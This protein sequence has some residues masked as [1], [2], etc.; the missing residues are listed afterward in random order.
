MKIKRCKEC[1]NTFLLGETGITFFDYIT[2]RKINVC[3]KC[4]H[5]VRDE[6]GLIV[7]YSVYDIFYDKNTKWEDMVSQTIV[8]TLN[9]AFPDYEFYFDGIPG[10]AFNICAKKEWPPEL[11]VEIK[12][13][14][15]N[16]FSDNGSDV[17]WG[18]VS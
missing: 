11:T 7:S 14:A 8:G 12:R 15:G 4:A 16:I 6:K 13:I 1:K 2:E 5:V 18:K 3:D 10:S 9:K 17:I